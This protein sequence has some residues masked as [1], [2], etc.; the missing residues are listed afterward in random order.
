VHVAR[1]PH[2]NGTVQIGTID[3]AGRDLG[4]VVV[5]GDLLAINAGIDVPGDQT[6]SIDLLSVHNLGSATN[7]ATS[8]VDGIISKIRVSG[9]IRGGLFWATSVGTSNGHV[10]DSLI[11]GGNVS[12]WTL[13]GMYGSGGEGD[14]H[15]HGNWVNSRIAGFYDDPMYIPNL[16]IDGS[17]RNGNFVVANGIHIGGSVTNTHLANYGLVDIAGTMRGGGIAT[18]GT[19]VVHGDLVDSTL[20]ARVAHIGGSMVGGQVVSA[21]VGP[22]LDQYSSMGSLNVAQNLEGVRIQK[23]GSVI[24]HGSMYF[25]QIEQLQSLHLYGSM[26]GGRIG[27]VTLVPNIDDP[28]AF[29]Y[30][31]SVREAVIGGSLQYGASIY[32][33]WIGRVVIHGDFE[34]GVIRSAGRI[35]KVEINGSLTGGRVVAGNEAPAYAT[36]RSVQGSI[37]AIFIGGNVGASNNSM[38]LSGSIASVG[39]TIGLLYIG[40]SVEGGAAERTGWISAPVGISGL[41]VG[42]EIHPGT[43][44]HAGVIETNP[45]GFLTIPFVGGNPLAGYVSSGA[46]FTTVITPVMTTPGAG[47]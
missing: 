40:G 5:E 25:S 4:R 34:Q 28:S 17:V 3:A 23:A 30:S 19:A 47:G 42:G 8:Y 7:P 35:G 32:G 43:G 15:V 33:E 26:V 1:G 16:Q 27:S 45:H 36:G 14:V 18:T 29:H 22:L 12:N 24:I 11:V 2:G 44:R 38:P 21:N 20:T 39:G 10:F 9:D 46:I 37:G 6:P 31:T 41:S 13:K